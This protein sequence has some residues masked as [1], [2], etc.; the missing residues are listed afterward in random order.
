MSLPRI[1]TALAEIAAELEA[2]GF[3]FLPLDEDV[4]MAIERRLGDL[5]GPLAGKLHTG[6][7]RN[8]QVATDI[9]MAVMDHSKRARRLIAQTMT[10]LLEL[11]RSHD[12]WPMP[13]YTHLQRAQP[14][15][16]GHHLLVLVLDALPRC[17]AVSGSR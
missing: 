9:C 4:H 13:G 10:R 2:G 5:I 6:R 11:A 14:V 7:S 15:Y 8:D 12:S 1:D 3:E 16:L 17:P